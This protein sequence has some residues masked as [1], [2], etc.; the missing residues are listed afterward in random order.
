M[1]AE[2][3]LFDLHRWKT[4]SDAVALYQKSAGKWATNPDLI[5]KY[6]FFDGS[7]SLGGGIYFWPD[8]EAAYRW[9]GREYEA[10]IEQTYGTKPRIQVFDARTG[11]I[12][13]V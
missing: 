7:R 13:E 8:L 2:I 1:I 4:S 6:Y 11:R 10:M 12:D 5:G 9:H 3:V